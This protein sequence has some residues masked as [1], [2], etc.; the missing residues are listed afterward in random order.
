[1][2]HLS[3]RSGAAILSGEGAL[4]AHACYWGDW[5]CKDVC[6][7][8]VEPGITA[9]GERCFY[10]W[11]FDE[12]IFP[13]TLKEIGDMAFFDCWRMGSYVYDAAADTLLGTGFTLPDGIEKI[14]SDA[15]SKCGNIAPA[16]FLPA[17]VK[18][19]PLLVRSNI[20]ISSSSSSSLMLAERAGCE[21]K[22]LLA[23]S[24]ID[25]DAATSKTY[26]I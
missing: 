11:A 2:Y 15:F 16:L 25:C 5:R 22:S 10:G 14:G 20:T 8:I 6:R 7:L 19:I 23:A 12:I 1:M 21:T 4:P 18:E 9:I 3:I 26:L 17:S 13:D 24:L